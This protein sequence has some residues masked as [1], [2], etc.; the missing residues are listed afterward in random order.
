MAGKNRKRGSITSARGKL[1][2]R[3]YWWHPEKLNKQH[4]WWIRTGEADTRENRSRLEAQLTLINLKIEGNAF[5]PCVEF[6]D[7][8]IAKFCR[9]SACVLVEPL[10]KAHQAPKTLGQLLDIYLIHEKSRAT[11]PNNIIEPKYYDTKRKG[12]NALRQTFHWYDEATDETVEYQP[13]TEYTIPQLNLEEVKA[14]LYGFQHREALLLHSKP[15]ASTSYM[16]ELYAYIRHAL[17]YGQFRRWW[18]THPL[19]EYR[20]SLLEASKQERNQI[21]NK[22]L[23]KPFSLDDR[24]R[25]LEHYRQQ[26]LTCPEAA[27]NGKEKLR[28]FFHYHYIVIGFNTGLRSPSEM[29]AFTWENVDFASQRLHVCRSRDASPGKENQTIREYTKTIKH[30]Y[31]PLN[32]KAT[33][34]LQA[35]QKYRQEEAPDGVF[36]NPRA[37][38]S[39]PYRLSNGWALI[40]DEKVIRREF[41]KVL[42][43]LE[44]ASLAN[45]GQYRMRH[46]FVTNVLDHTNLSDAQVAA[47]IGDT[48]ETMK[49]HYEG[50]CKH[51]WQNLDNLAELNKLNPPEETSGGIE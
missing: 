8:K 6:P 12:I 34:S 19:L 18:R 44:I 23:H 2:I 45:Q 35:L 31:V 24:D 33:E 37:G 38:I 7:H 1:S 40:T 14:W 39:N 29:T 43:E 25:I 26:W 50:H 32:D 47:L 28:L 9:C 30:R 48:V 5:F 22:R 36:W 20:G 51:R 4:R 11:G 41:N 15:P 16:N 21:A 46:T 42:A 17:R 3:F 49:R 27:Y 13:L 10:D